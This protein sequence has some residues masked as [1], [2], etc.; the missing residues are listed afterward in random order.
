MAKV[1][2][3]DSTK[4]KYVEQQELTVIADGNAKWHSHFGK[5]LGIFL[6]ISTYFSYMIEK[7]CS[8][9]YAHMY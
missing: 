1:Q 7:S 2:N 6:Q 3:T 8:F 9:L 4:Y 5:Q